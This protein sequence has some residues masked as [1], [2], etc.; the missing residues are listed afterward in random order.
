MLDNFCFCYFYAKNCLGPQSSA[1]VCKH[2][3]AVKL[4]EAFAGS[5]EEKLFVKEI[6]EQDYHPLLL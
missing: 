1:Q 5:F 4:A 2:V 3:L 6:D